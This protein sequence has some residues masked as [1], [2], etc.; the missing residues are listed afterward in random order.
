MIIINMYIVY[1]I[2]ILSG[3]LQVCPSVKRKKRWA[4]EDLRHAIWY[5][6]TVSCPKKM[7]WVNLERVSIMRWWRWVR[8]MF[9][10]SSEYNKLLLYEPIFFL[11]RVKNLKN[12]PLLFKINRKTWYNYVMKCI[13]LMCTFY[14]DI[15]TYLLWLVKIFI[16]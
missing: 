1:C 6:K 13:L 15:M 16:D 11:S 12:R 10:W 2:L 8:K 4:Y 14:K 3:L 7:F 9:K 5:L